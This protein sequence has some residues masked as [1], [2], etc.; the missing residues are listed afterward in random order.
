MKKAYLLCL[1]LK[2]SLSSLR[3]KLMAQGM[4][5]CTDDPN[6]VWYHS[7]IQALLII[8][9]IDLT[10]V[11]KKDP[12]AA[13]QGAEKKDPEKT[14]EEKKCESEFCKRIALAKEECVL[15]FNQVMDI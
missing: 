5:Q 8:T 9:V 15:Q 7:A 12:D 10:Q 11:D 14:E 1:G 13:S 2:K 3:L 6:Q 4:A